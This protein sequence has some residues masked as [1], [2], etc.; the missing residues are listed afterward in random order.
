[1]KN[2]IVLTCALMLAAPLAFAG[3]EVPTPQPAAAV[4]TEKAPV[5]AEKATEKPASKKLAKAHKPKQHGMKKSE[6]SEKQ[7]Q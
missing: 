4:S 6:K 5:Q 1:M 7:I 3:E 2:Q